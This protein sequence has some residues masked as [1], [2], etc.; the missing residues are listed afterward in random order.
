[1]NVWKLAAPAAL[2]LIMPVAPSFA[3]VATVDCNKRQTITAAIAKFDRSVANTVTV[4]GACTENVVV[5]GHR[6][7][8]LT[9]AA[10]ATIT[11]ADV[12]LSTVSVLGTSRLTMFDIE[13]NGGDT[14]VSC[15]DRSVCI[16]RAVDIFGGFTGLAL[17]KQSSA[18]VLDGSIRNSTNTGVG[19]FGASSVNIRSDLSASPVLISGHP[20]G[21]QVQD[22]SF[23]RTDN[24]L[25]TENQTGVNADRGAVIKILGNSQGQS[26]VINNTVSGVQV[27]ASTA[28]LSGVISGNPEGVIVRQ[29]SYVTFIQATVT[30]NTG[31][32][33][34]CAHSTAITNPVLGSGDVAPFIDFD[35]TN[36]P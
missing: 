36:C 34:R 2:L 19:V 28:Q 6:D 3:A 27:R 26:Q 30:G 10:G 23:L 21:I 20:V 33:V 7:L 15:D 5:N 14:G 35:T 16:L 17:Q 24:A 9:S 13:V 18:D 8:T 25:I 22:G 29:L 31:Y 4:S 12:N 1:M 11:A 32:S